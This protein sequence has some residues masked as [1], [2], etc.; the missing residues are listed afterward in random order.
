VNSRIDSPD[1]DADRKLRQ[2]LDARLPGF[3]MV[4]GAGSGKTTSLIKALSHILISRGD[5]LRSDVRKVACITYTEIAAREIANELANDPIIHISTI[6]SF[7]W[8]VVKPF[9]YDIRQWVS[10]K[11]RL[12]LQELIYEQAGFSSRIQQKRREDTTAR[13]RRLR[14]QIPMIDHVSTFTY[15]TASDYGRGVLGHEDITTIAPELITTKP[16]LA[17]L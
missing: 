16:L 1:T 11:A 3:T 17:N 7:L 12:R 2:V 15:G 5:E 6:H 10:R 4:A 13:I 14:D 9:Q 8:T